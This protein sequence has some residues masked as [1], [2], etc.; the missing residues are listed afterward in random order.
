MLKRMYDY[1][2]PYSET[3]QGFYQMKRNTIDVIIIGTS[4]GACS[5]NPNEMYK[6]AKI[7]AYNL[8]SSLQNV[9]V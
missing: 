5:Y 7:R 6:H 4:H 2:E 8:S 1:F 3:Y 9:W